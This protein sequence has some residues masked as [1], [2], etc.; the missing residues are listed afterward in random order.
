MAIKHYASPDDIAATVGHLA[1]LNGRFIT[2]ASIAVDGGFLGMSAQGHSMAWAP[3]SRRSARDC[4]GACP[5]TGRWPDEARP[6]VVGIAVAMTSLALLAIALRHLPAGTAY[7]V[8][9]GIGIYGVALFGILFL[10]EPMSAGKLVFLTLIGVGV[11]GLR[12]MEG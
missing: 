11:A 4:L 12:M 6:S 1:G 5:E 2:G 8:W 9:V 10:G 7:A 3:L